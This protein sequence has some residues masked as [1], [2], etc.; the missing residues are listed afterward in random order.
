[1]YRC[2]L[3]WHQLAMDC[4]LT[5]VAV[6]ARQPI[7]TTTPFNVMAK[8]G[9]KACQVYNIVGCAFAQQHPKDLHV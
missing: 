9:S 6:P 1:M 3:V 7:K 5:M 2:A 8:R 4:Q